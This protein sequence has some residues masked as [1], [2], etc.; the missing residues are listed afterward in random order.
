MKIL[1]INP[2][3]I[4]D[5]LFSTPLLKAIKK[6]YPEAVIAYMCNKRTAGIL[7]NDP[8]ISALY[9]FEKDEYR[10]IWEE[11]RIKCL[12][13]A[14]SLMKSIRIQRYDV[15]VDIS[16]A[17]IYSL[18]LSVFAKI[19][20][21]IGFNY[22]KRGR[23]LTHRIDI[24]GFDKKHV[25]EYY[26]ELGKALG[27]DTQ[28][29]EMSISVAKEDSEWADKFLEASGISKNDR[30][31]G[32]I[33]GC[34]ASWGEDASYRRW[35]A[36]KFAGAADHFSARHGYKTLIFGDS[37]EL[38]L[39]SK[40]QSVMKTAAVQ[41]CGKTTLGQFAALLDRCDL[42]ITNDGGPLHMA[43]ALRKKTISIFGP[44]DEHVYGPY[45]QSSLHIVITSDE[46]CRPCYKNFKYVKCETLK[47][48]NNIET[49]KV[50][51]A[52]EALMVRQ[53]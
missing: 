11:S 22:R 36:D 16:L 18:V 21:R 10:K 34:G 29:K 17:Y 38:A 15:L 3:G 28:D 13:E 24:R 53:P 52:A 6:K 39:C 25:I 32:I 20:V 43:V 47:C 35:P 48:L 49:D 8:N 23:F 9:I 51:K 2:F 33:P 31:C 44:V 46:P 5:V 19:P 45:P 50:I 4:G 7:K 42:V 1:I 27:L 12:R 40:V 14:Y 26:L 30:I 37:K 41:V